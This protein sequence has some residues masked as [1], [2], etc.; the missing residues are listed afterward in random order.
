MF[1]GRGRGRERERESAKSGWALVP[2][3]LNSPLKPGRER[4]RERGDFKGLGSPEQNLS[5][6]GRL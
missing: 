1:R 4:E 6:K 2:G 3:G 5:M